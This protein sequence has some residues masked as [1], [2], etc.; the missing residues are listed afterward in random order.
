LWANS[1][2]TETN[3]TFAFTNFTVRIANTRFTSD[4]DTNNDG[5]VQ[6]ELTAENEVVTLVGSYSG[7]PTMVT[8]ATGDVILSGQ[9]NSVALELGVAARLDIKGGSPV[10][11]INVKSRGVL[12]VALYGSRTLDVRDIDPESI[13]LGCTATPLRWNYTDM[14]GDGRLD[15]NLKFATQDVVPSFQN[16]RNRARVTLTLTAVLEGSGI[17]VSGS[18]QVTV[19]KPGNAFRQQPMPQPKTKKPHPVKKAKKTK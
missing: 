5:L 15:L 6:F 8:N 9:L 1:C 11:P 14:N 12:P 4:T 7:V 18:D 13:R 17:P 19:L 2:S 10:A 16:V 3:F